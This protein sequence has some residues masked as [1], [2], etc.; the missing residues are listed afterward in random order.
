[1]RLSAGPLLRRGFIEESYVS[2]MIGFIEEQGFYAV[3]DG[4]FALLH[5][6]GAE[7]IRKGT[8]TGS[9]DPDAHGED[10]LPNPRF[11]PVQDEGGG[12]PVRA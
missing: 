9:G 2:N 1:M 4:S 7:G 5:G 12:V 8:Y 11:S 6:K 10:H 3:S